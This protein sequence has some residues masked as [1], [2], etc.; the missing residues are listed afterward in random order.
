M[1]LFISVSPVQTAETIQLLSKPLKLYDLRGFS[2]LPLPTH[3]TILKT[4][5][6][7][8]VNKSTIKICSLHTQNT[9]Q[10]LIKNTIIFVMLA[11]LY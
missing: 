3:S 4:L 11:V 5:V 10:Q 7:Y 8:P 9:D 1:M 2:I 6:S